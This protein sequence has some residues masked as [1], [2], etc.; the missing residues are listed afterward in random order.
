MDR[1]II[2]LKNVFQFFFYEQLIKIQYDINLEVSFYVVFQVYRE[3]FEYLI[4]DFKI[5]KFLLF[6]IKNEYEMML[7][8]Q[9]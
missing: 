7:V 4:E 9:R 6:G 2:V 1:D 5:Y 8:Y 3:V